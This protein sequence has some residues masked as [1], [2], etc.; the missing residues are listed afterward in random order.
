M[1]NLNK[2]IKKRESESK[3]ILCRIILINYFDNYDPKI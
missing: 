3:F 1:F 2:I